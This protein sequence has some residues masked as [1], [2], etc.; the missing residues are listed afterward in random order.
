[1]NIYAMIQSDDWLNEA[2]LKRLK[3]E[4]RIMKATTVAGASAA[5]P[6]GEV[7]ARLDGAITAVKKTEKTVTWIFAVF[8]LEAAAVQSVPTK[9]GRGDF[10]AF[11][12]I[13]RLGMGGGG[14]ERK[15]YEGGIK[16]S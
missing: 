14:V 1:M 12:L 10:T 8:H 3:A 9:M 5:P 16:K 6:P 2:M 4:L 7:M 13:L 15:N 11:A